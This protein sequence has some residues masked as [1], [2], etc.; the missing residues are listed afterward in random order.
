MLAALEV[1]SYPSASHGGDATA[2]AELVAPIAAG[3][4]SYRWTAT[5][6]ASPERIS[7][8]ITS[9]HFDYSGPLTFRIVADD[10]SEVGEKQTLSLT[11]DYS[12]FWDT[13]PLKRGGTFG[14]DQGGENKVYGSASF[15]PLGDLFRFEKGE[16]E[17][18]FKGIWNTASSALGPSEQQ[19]RFLP[20][21]VGQTY[22]IDIQGGGYSEGLW[23]GG[24]DL[25]H[26]EAGGSIQIDI[27]L[28][29]VEPD[30]GVSD[31]RVDPATG[32]ID[33]DYHGVNLNDEADI[34]LFW[35]RE[36]S[37]TGQIVPL[38][39][40][41]HTINVPDSL[42]G[43]NS[44]SLAISD[45][46]QQPPK[47]ATHLL[48][49]ADPA[50]QVDEA[51]EDNN[52]DAVKLQADFDLDIRFVGPTKTSNTGGA[53]CSVC[54]VDAVA[55]REPYQ[56][57]ADV[58]NN[59]AIPYIVSFNVDE[60]LLDPAGVNIEPALRTGG[61]KLM[62]VEPIRVGP[63][64]T[65]PVILDRITKSWDWIPSE[66]PFT[67]GHPLV[68]HVSWIA[69]AEEAEN[70][71]RDQFS[72]IGA[73][74]GKIAP[75]LGN[76]EFLYGLSLSQPI[77]DLLYHVELERPDNQNLLVEDTAQIRLETP[78]RFK[79]KFVRAALLGFGADAAKGK[80]VM[81]GL[82]GLLSGGAT[83]PAAGAL[84]AG[85]V[86]LGALS[87]SAYRQAVDPPDPN[88]DE[89]VQ[90]QY[91]QIPAGDQGHGLPSYLAQL[92]SDRSALAAAEAASRDKAL[93]ALEAGDWFWY[94]EQLKSAGGFS[95]ASIS[96]DA[97][98]AVA[99]HLFQPV[100]DAA[101]NDP[102]AIAGAIT[103]SFPTELETL[104]RDR[105]GM[106][107]A[108]IEALRQEIIAEGADK[109]FADMVNGTEPTTN[110]ALSAA[111]SF[112]EF[113]TATEIRREKLASNKYQVPPNVHARLTNLNFDVETLLSGPPSLGQLELIETYLQASR[114]ALIASADASE[115]A[116]LVN[117]LA[118]AHDYLIRFARQD[119]STAAFEAL[120]D[121]DSW[122][123]EDTLETDLRTKLAELND[124]LA[125][126][127][128]NDAG[129]KLGDMVAA[130][131]AQR[132]TGFQSGFYADRTIGF[133][134]LLFDVSTGA[135]LT[136][137][138][139]RPTWLVDTYQAAAE[140]QVDLSRVFADLDSNNSLNYQVINNTN[141]AVAGAV[142]NGAVLTVNPAALADGETQLTVRARDGLNRVAESIV[143]VVVRGEKPEMQVL[144]V[145][146]QTLDENR[147]LTVQVEAALRDS[148]GDWDFNPVYF[149]FA[150]SGDLPGATV[151]ENGVLRWF[152]GEEA[153][154][155]TFDVRVDVTNT[156]SEL[157]LTMSV[158]FQ[159]TV[160]DLLSPPVISE[161]PILY[162]PA[163]SPLEFL[164]EAIDYDL[165]S[166]SLT[167]SLQNAPAG[168]SIDASGNFSWTPNVAGSSSFSVVV[169]DSSG[170]ED[171]QAVQVNIYSG[172]EPNRD[173]D[174]APLQLD[175]LTYFGAWGG[176]AEVRTETGNF[177]S[178]PTHAFEIGFLLSDSPN[179]GPNDV[180]LLLEDGAP[181][182]SH[183]M[184]N[185]GEF[186]QPLLTRLRLPDS[187]P[188]GFNGQQFWILSQLDP[189]GAW[190]E[191]NELNNF[192]VGVGLDADRIMISHEEPDLAPVGVRVP[193]GVGQW[194]ELV[195]VDT[196]VSNLG[197]AAAGPF[198]VEWLLSRVEEGGLGDDVTLSLQ[199][200]ESG[201]DVG[202]LDANGQ[203]RHSVNVRLPA[204]KPSGWEQ[205]EYFLLAKVD[206]EDAVDESDETNNLGLPD[207]NT[208]SALVTLTAADL[209]ANVSN[210]PFESSW[211][212][213]I[214]LRSWITNEG[215]LPAGPFDVS[216]WLST[217]ATGD[218]RVLLPL[219]DDST[220]LRVDG[221]QP[222]GFVD[223]NVDLQLPDSPIAGAMKQRFWLHAQVDVQ[224]EVNEIF[225]ANNFTTDIAATH[226]SII[227]PAE[228]APDLGGA[229]RL[230]NSPAWGGQAD[231]RFS[232]N[233]FG[234]ANAENSFTVQW[235]L[236]NDGVKDD[237]DVLLSLS[238]GGTHYLAAPLDVNE[239]VFDININLNMPEQM[240][241]GWDGE[242]G[243][244][245]QVIDASSQYDEIREW[246]ND[247]W[248]S[249]FE[250]LES[251]PDLRAYP[252]RSQAPKESLNRVELP[253]SAWGESL[254]VTGSLQNRGAANSGP[255]D[256]RWYLSNDDTLDQN[257]TLLPLT[258][259]LDS[260][261]H[262]GISSSGN[263]FWDYDFTLQ[264][265]AVAPAN[266]AGRT[267]FHLLVSADHDQEVLETREFNN[268]ASSRIF[269]TDTPQ[270]N[271]RGIG[272]NA[273]F[274][275]DP[276]RW[277]ESFDISAEIQNFGNADLTQDFDL[278]WYI[279][280]DTQLSA[281]DIML[282][283]DNGAD[284]QRV[285]TNIAGTQRF[286]DFVTIDYTNALTS[287]TL[288]LPAKPDGWGESVTYLLMV[289]DSSQEVSESNEDDNVAAL[290]QGFDFIELPIDNR[291]AHNSA[292]PFDVNDDGAFR[293]NDVFLV[294]GALR[295]GPIGGTPNPGP[296][297]VD[298]DDDQRLTLR[299]GF[300]IIDGFRQ[301][302]G[303]GEAEAAVLFEARDEDELW[304]PLDPTR[305]LDLSDE[306]VSEISRRWRD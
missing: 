8:D 45:L 59:T 99:E 239:D 155:G 269:V 144:A 106:D 227:D 56:L 121:E 273:F 275:G 94:A 262:L 50:N 202:G 85:S 249:S 109:L 226:V 125:T 30:V 201:V 71:F 271:L 64:Q 36:L 5:G 62:D 75:L 70:T 73:A 299:D 253:T 150:V 133:L 188:N 189:N 244:L 15:A 279:S 108:E 100:R 20:V 195:T 212:D 118:D 267:Q 103:P 157:P 146:N 139:V 243:F 301:E 240:P 38:G 89:Y 285:T 14:V 102:A 289:V 207:L 184:L 68:T 107:A 218:N 220:S 165:P 48:A 124:L 228:Q 19:T 211:G 159:V 17:S 264:L 114:E 13:D 156:T 208:A 276:L 18:P 43:E 303:S 158:D 205:T 91:T 302:V 83:W 58:T 294:I 161:I 246:N 145:D 297:Y 193:G 306:L 93:G 291:T 296:P 113:V 304:A 147:L 33:V 27:D 198:R 278:Q 84:G 21:E 52:R 257:D 191:S 233:N 190:N 129:L 223:L 41:V 47:N 298:V 76:A 49:V 162:A 65:V 72:K 180:P 32:K 105:A 277:Q 130:A 142:V 132:S 283:R 116:D 272:L 39:A 250:I 173:I 209:Q 6:S 236:S 270:P 25:H 10:P 259:G 182:A 248:S 284:H 111:A 176:V 295:E 292:F 197:K 92:T 1:L 143:H 88:Y 170:L 229:V 9:G 183:P 57:V 127:K 287:P 152:A 164:V 179:G 219:A 119:F 166:E 206:S 44:V 135:N 95:A 138:V 46:A 112:E 238:S 234:N 98:L 222:Q 74:A 87:D 286:G 151:D 177:G 280:K 4:Q 224:N 185:A 80:A 300:L 140:V 131:E 28:F 251:D 261:E 55:K 35:A 258:G 204:I 137:A 63:G 237:D 194:G 288:E 263:T 168:A 256:V 172:S 167:Y 40:S 12:Y 79:S 97:R 187:L 77:V 42:D 154:G 215:G 29:G 78:T 245:L 268:V 126:G 23:V 31:V 213:T 217:N 265:P 242:Q 231:V 120:L 141:P 175:T 225:D 2:S 101:V 163:N 123:I 282:L 196:E 260:H 241:E 235:W 115:E 247:V 24:T 230:N 110:A 290:G 122:A 117:H 54:V 293:L 128:F 90:V 153:G 7:D 69:A 160:N 149:D 34:K 136:P 186:G 274:G 203:W 171:V 255:F 37:S 67:G 82:A 104:L 266:A 199:G 221:V 281:D 192:A 61:N 148:F 26:G 169:R 252:P 210:A 96:L 16:P 51:V 305:Q 60:Q 22:T 232:L 181:T 254:R 214:S 216:W 134:R 178:E 66:N 86:A 200:G 81:L 53:L 11:S 3:V 174:L